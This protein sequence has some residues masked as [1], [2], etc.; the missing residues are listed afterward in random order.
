MQGRYR[1]LLITLG[2]GLC[3]IFGTN[4]ALAWTS[5]VG[6]SPKGNVALVGTGMGPGGSAIV[7][8]DL[9]V[10]PLVLQAGIRRPDGS[11]SATKDVANPSDL[12][13]LPQ[14]QMNPTGTTAVFLWEGFD[15][16]NYRVQLRTLGTNGVLGPVITATPPNK[17]VTRP[18]AFGVDGSGNVVLAWDD[19]HRIQVRTISAG[20]TL[21]STTTVSPMGEFS[22]DPRVA[23]DPAGDAVV[24]WESSADANV[25]AVQRQS[26]GTVGSVIDVGDILGGLQLGIDS[27]GEATFFMAGT[28]ESAARQL[29]S[30]G[31]LGPVLTVNTGSNAASDM[32]TNGGGE[33]LFAWPKP[34]KLRTRSL[35]S[36]GVLGTAHVITSGQTFYPD[37]TLNATGDSVIGWR[38]ATGSRTDADVARQAA[39]GTVGSTHLL[40]SGVT[41]GP[42]V[43]LNGGGQAVAAWVSPKSSA[44]VRISVDP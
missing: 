4:Q 39:D 17:D 16:T 38:Q 13:F 29:A 20:G 22:Q 33:A 7:G 26:D 25:H 41:D 19:S 27:S 31:T 18:P 9:R 5:P 37:V 44:R 14:M 3:G 21:G 12:D 28:D 23:V 10:S 30:N 15:G 35:S 6:I 11:L 1:G 2:V 42:L 36:T 43:S 34:A 24:A 40:G 8:W 32:A